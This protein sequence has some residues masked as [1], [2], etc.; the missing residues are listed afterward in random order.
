MNVPYY[1]SRLGP[2]RGVFRTGVPVLNY[3]HVGPARR[4]A[5]LKWLYVS[6]KVF[7]RQMAELQSEGFSTSELLALSGKSCKRVEVSVLAPARVAVPA[8]DR[9]EALPPQPVAFG[10][11]G[12]VAAVQSEG[13][14]ERRVVLTF[15]D[16]FC[17]VFE[18]ALPVLQRY[19]LRGILFLVSDLLG[20]SNEWQTKTGDV[21]EP[22]MDAAQV[23][24]W[25]GAGQQLGSHTKSHLRL[26]QLSHSDAREQIAGSKKSLEDQFGARIDHFCYPYGD[27]NKAV[28][29]LVIEAGYK[30][31]C[32]SDYGINTPETS[33]F[34]LNRYIARYHTRSL[35]TIWER[36]L[37]HLGVTREPRGRAI[38]GVQARRA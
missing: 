26:T 25:L 14:P 16:G 22:L 32:T 15:D 34:E 7:E 36:L 21:M 31:A 20:K 8:G 33:P 13:N 23:R 17:D 3:H 28:R 18:H 12:E 5:R 4:G 9:D 30:T 6:P 11:P 10:L 29:D 37:V 27:W 24:E 1:Y 2:F 38:V 19:Q 35:K